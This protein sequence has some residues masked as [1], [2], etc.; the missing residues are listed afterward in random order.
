MLG[1]FYLFM[2]ERSLLL[3]VDFK[4][5]NVMESVEF[6]FLKN[7]MKTLQPAFNIGHFLL[8]LSACK[9]KCLDKNLN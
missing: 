4:K 7:H 5:F 3:Q 6:F 9:P 8:P 2:G 1:F